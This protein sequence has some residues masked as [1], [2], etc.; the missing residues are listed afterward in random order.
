MTSIVKPKIVHQGLRRNA[1]GLT[2][3]DYEGGMSTLCAGCG[4]DSITAALV[5]AF[6]ELDIPP[7]SVAKMSG[8]GCS[9]KTPAYFLS[10]SHGFNSVHGRMPS[11]ATGAG[12][13]NRELHLLGVSGDGDSLSIGLGQ[14]AHVVRRNLDMLY[15]IENNG[16]YGLT[17]GQFSASADVGSKAKRGEVNK[18]PPIDPVQLAMVL[19]GTFVARSF[20]GDKDQL[21]PLI[22]AGIRHQGFALIDVISPCVTFNDHEDSTKS[23]A[24]AREFHHRVIHADFIPPA[25]EI[26]VAYDQ[27]EVMPIELHDGSR[28]LLR[29]VSKDYNV[30]NRG[31]AIDYLRAHHRRGEIVTGL[32]YIDE[33][34]AEMHA[35]NGTTATPLSQLPYETLCPGAET[36]AKLQQRYR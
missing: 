20:S 8:I 36:L 14:F 33:S 16:V 25:E 23:Y 22:K 29:K 28:I 24:H 17:K 9:S 27:G 18:Q 35:I 34:E 3:R 1:L 26:K 4:H 19:G 30:T 15:I 6:F 21:V 32:L 2:V 12:A 5:Q 11:I 31:A 7:H 13:A 10:A